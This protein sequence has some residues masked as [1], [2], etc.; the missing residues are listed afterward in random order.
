MKRVEQRRMKG[1]NKE[2]KKYK[3]NLIEAQ[4][5]SMLKY[6]KKNYIDQ[7]TH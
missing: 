5:G 1:L 6:I 3:T 7:H 2:E 4:K